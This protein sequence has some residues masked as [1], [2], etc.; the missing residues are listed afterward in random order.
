MSAE[1]GLRMGAVEAGTSLAF[2][3]VGV[4]AIWD[5]LRLGT[6]W[7]AEGP[8]SGTFPFWVGLILLGA[9]I[10]TLV[11]ATRAEAGLFASWAQLRMVASVLVPTVLFVAA[12]PFT[13]IYLASA[14]LVAW[15]M[16]QLGGFAVSPAVASGVAVALVT[17]IVF[18]IWFLVALPKG[19]IETWLGY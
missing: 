19:P 6:G 15:F 1:R 10:G 18:E 3:L 12:I 11:Q 14:A 2:A 17:F 5:S 13:G 16:R 9:S 4:A 7:S 8:Q